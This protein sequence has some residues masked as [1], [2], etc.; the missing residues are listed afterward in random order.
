M[1]KETVKRAVFFV[2][3]LSS[4]IL[5]LG[6]AGIDIP[7]GMFPLHTTYCKY[8]C[9]KRK[10]EQLAITSIKPIFNRR[11]NGKAKER[12]TGLIKQYYVSAATAVNVFSWR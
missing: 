1:R 5:M 11:I 4:A 10:A 9:K 8:T 2:K 6:R 7:N 12:L 3:N